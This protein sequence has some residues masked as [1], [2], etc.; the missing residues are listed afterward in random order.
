MMAGVIAPYNA[1]AVHI[2]PGLAIV[3]LLIVGMIGLAWVTVNIERLW[4]AWEQW[5]GRLLLHTLYTAKGKVC[6]LKF[7]AFRPFWRRHFRHKKAAPT[8]HTHDKFSP[9]VVK[10]TRPVR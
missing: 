10:S 1:S 5:R 4:T 7:S 2:L 3:A 6:I 8:K 9:H